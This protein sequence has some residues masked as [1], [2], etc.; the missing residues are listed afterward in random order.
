MLWVCVIF[1]AVGDPG[2]S[3]ASFTAGCLLFSGA[4]KLSPEFLFGDLAGGGGMLLVS[5]LSAEARSGLVPRVLV[6]LRNS[7][8]GGMGRP[9]VV[10]GLRGMAGSSASAL[11]V[12]F[13]SCIGIFDGGGGVNWDC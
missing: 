13:C 6:V 9:P 11:A 10:L 2:E 12:V 1:D 7:D 5:G 4:T 3:T 8:R